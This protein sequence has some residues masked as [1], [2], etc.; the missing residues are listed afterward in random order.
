MVGKGRGG[1]RAGGWRSGGEPTGAKSHSESARRD[2]V[3]P[4]PPPPGPPLPPARPLPPPPPPPLP[5]P[6]LRPLANMPIAACTRASAERRPLGK[7]TWRE[8]VGVRSPTRPAVQFC[9]WSERSAPRHCSLSVRGARRQCCSSAATRDTSSSASSCSHRRTCAPHREAKGRRAQAPIAR[10]T[11]R[12]CRRVPSILAARTT[13]HRYHRRRTCASSSAGNGRKLLK[14][15]RLLGA[16]TGFTSSSSAPVPAA[17]SHRAVSRPKRR[18]SCRCEG[19]EARVRGAEAWA[20]VQR[21][22]VR[23]RGWPRVRRRR[24]CGGGEACAAAPPRGPRPPGPRRTRPAAARWPPARPACRPCHA[25]GALASPPAARAPPAAAP[26]S[27]VAA[28]AARSRPWRPSWSARC[29]QR[30]GSRAWEMQ[31]CGGDAVAVEVQRRCGAAA[32]RSSTARRNVRHTAAAATSHAS[33][34]SFGSGFH[35]PSPPPAATAQTSGAESTFACSSAASSVA[36]TYA[37]SIEARSSAGASVSS[38]AK[39]FALSAR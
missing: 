15:L 5:P 6:P 7:L 25:A 30:R 9:R 4:L 19:A 8:T 12:G 36:S 21:R 37:S 33:T 24:G 2:S 10:F 3:P 23:G 17:W 1:R 26:R 14:A 39:I 11:M 28:C 20:R 22:G 34:A 27:A 13:R 38:S 35:T 29:P 31:R 16:F 18:A 32:D